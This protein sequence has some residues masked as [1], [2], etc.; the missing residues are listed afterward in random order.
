MVS[1]DPQVPAV[2]PQDWSGVSKPIQQP[3]SITKA[4]TSTG[5]TLSTLANVGEEAVGLAKTTMQDYLKNQVETGVN[6]L[7][8]DYTS[9]YQTIRSAQNTLIP[10]QQQSLVDATQPPVP[11]GLQ[12]GLDRAKQLGIA[13]I[14][15]LGKVNDTQYTMQ[16]NSLAKQMRAQYPGFKDYIDEQ[17]KSV[18]GVD[19]ANAVMKNLLEDINHNATNAKS[20]HDKT[21]TMLRDA[22]TQGIPNAPVIFSMWQAGKINTDQANAYVYKYSSADYQRKQEM[23]DRTNNQGRLSD[24]TT[25]VKQ[26]FSRTAASDTQAMIDT[27]HIAGGTETAQGLVDVITRANAEGAKVDP[28]KLEQGLMGLTAMKTQITAGLWRKANQPDA[29]GNTTLS[30]IGEAEVRA[31]IAAQTAPVDEYIKYIADEK[32]GY[33][34]TA[35]RQATALGETAQRDLLVHKD[36]GAQMQVIDGMAKIAPQWGDAMYKAGLLSNLDKKLVPIYQEGLG[37]A[38]TQLDP[39]NPAT[40]KQ[41]VQ[42]AKANNVAPNQRLVDN[43]LNIPKIIADPKAP[44]AVKLNVAKYAFDPK[45][46]GFMNELKMDYTNQKGQFIPGKYSAYDRMLSTDII[47]GMDKLRKQG[48]DGQTAWNNMKAWGENEF[49][50]LFREDLQN[51]QRASTVTGDAKPMIGKYD[52]HWDSDNNRFLPIATNPSQSTDDQGRIKQINVVLNRVN[53]GLSQLAEVQKR[54]GGNTSAY[55]L[56]VLHNSDPALSAIT[57]PIKTSIISA[58]D[59]SL[60]KLEDTFANRK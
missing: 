46:W 24:I 53:G 45:N 18:S 6:K 48:G 60:Q 50:V 47:D 28:I 40:I 13:Q 11:G 39:L 10:N 29:N 5:I 42:A 20:E 32:H 8:D 19:P 31:Q 34:H 3:E 15:N 30:F 44:D 25:S 54:D 21:T 51:I 56:G 35:L 52:I 22:V 41:D 43:Y 26:S 4:D 9:A 57:N 1:F 27:I 36:V 49:P 17:M 16:L 55:L 58:H 59:K 23:S 12:S 2:Q 37:R 7:R 38:A 33:A 14:Q